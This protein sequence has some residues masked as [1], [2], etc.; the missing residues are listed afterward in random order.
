MTMMASGCVSSSTGAERGAARRCCASSLAGSSCGGRL[1]SCGAWTAA[2]AATISPL[3]LSLTVRIGRFSLRCASP[4]D[5]PHAQPLQQRRAARTCRGRARRRRASPAWS[6]SFCSRSP[7]LRATSRR[8]VRRGTTTTPSSSATMTSPGSTSAPATDDR[9]VDRAGRR[10]HRALRGDRA[11]PDREAHRGQLRDVADAG[12]R[13]RCRSRPAARS[14]VASSSPNMPSVDGEVVVTTSTSPGR[15]LLDGRVDHEVV[16]G[17]AE[18]GHRPAGDAAARVDG[19]Q[20]GGE[21]PG[22]A[23]RLVRGRHAHPGECRDGLGVGE[24]AAANDDVAH[25]P[26]VPP[27]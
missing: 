26:S 18:H 4:V 11:R 24:T 3:V 1:S 2:A 13:R 22:A 21:H 8:L 12:V 5:V 15:A 23:L 7:A 19:A 27:F 20:V 10:L 14:E 16:A 6:A 17:M 9:H 25:R